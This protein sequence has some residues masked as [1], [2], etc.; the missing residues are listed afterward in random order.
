MAVL[1]PGVAVLGALPPPRQGSLLLHFLHVF[2]TIPI[3]I[4]LL[5]THWLAWWSS[6][7]PK[8]QPFRWQFAHQAVQMQ[9]S[10]PFHFIL[11]SAEQ[12]HSLMCAAAMPPPP[13]I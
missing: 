3:Q 5:G 10:V 4:E 7:A 11:G 2:L 13:V 8:S 9:L 1:Q 6:E 12:W